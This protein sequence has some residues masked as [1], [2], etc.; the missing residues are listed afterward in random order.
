MP[1]STYCNATPAVMNREPCQPILLCL[2]AYLPG[3]LPGFLKVRLTV[4]G[5]GFPDRFHGDVNR[6]K[7]NL[8]ETEVLLLWSV[9]LGSQWAML[10]RKAAAYN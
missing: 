4:Q 7:E 8:E 9:M 3:S 6:L 5:T 10:L 1:W 2:P